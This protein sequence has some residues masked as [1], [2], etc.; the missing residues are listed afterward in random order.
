MDSSKKLVLNSMDQIKNKVN[1]LDEKQFVVNS[2]LIASGGILYN[3][4]SS[5][6]GYLENMKQG[7]LAMKDLNLELSEYG[8]ESYMNELTEYEASL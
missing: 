6:D 1:K 7:Y 4:E 3:I 2:K 8:V 5:E